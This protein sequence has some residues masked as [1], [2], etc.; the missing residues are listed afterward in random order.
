M[1]TTPFHFQFLGYSATNIRHRRIWD[2]ESDEMN[3]YMK[4]MM[5]VFV[6]NSFSVYAKFFEKLLFQFFGKFCAR[7]K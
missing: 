7:T 3:L 5:E 2:P 1:A 4:S 6:K